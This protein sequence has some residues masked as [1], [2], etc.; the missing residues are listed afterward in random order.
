MY[1]FMCV[2]V[3][4]ICTHVLLFL[5]QTSFVLS[6]QWR[7]LLCMCLIVFCF[8]SSHKCRWSSI[9]TVCFIHVSSIYGTASRCSRNKNK[10]EHKILSV[11]TFI[12]VFCLCYLNVEQKSRYNF[13]HR[14][15]FTNNY[16]AENL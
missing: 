4:C 14:A 7:S 2:C 8:S 3:C 13:L 11:N 6:V 10:H 1:L 9:A 16:G 15:G 12:C 5:V